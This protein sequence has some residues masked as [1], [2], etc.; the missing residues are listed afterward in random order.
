MHTCTYTCACMR[1]L[2]TRTH[3]RTC[4]FPRTYA[5]ARKPFSLSRGVHQWKLCSF[6]VLMG[7]CR[8][9]LKVVGCRLSVTSWAADLLQSRGLLICRKVVGCLSACCNAVVGCRLAVK[10][11]SAGFSQSREFQTKTDEIRS[12]RLTTEKALSR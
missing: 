10:L 4:T 3:A 11:W 6:T 5:R 8:F 9:A 2:R 12:N 7:S 1:A